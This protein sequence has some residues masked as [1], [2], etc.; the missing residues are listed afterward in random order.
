MRSRGRDRRDCHRALPALR[1]PRAPAASRRAASRRAA[2]AARNARPRPGSQSRRQ[3]SA[4]APPSSSGTQAS[5]S[6]ASSSARQ[7]GAFQ[8]IV[9]GPVD[10]LRIGEVRENPRRRFG[11]DMVAFARHMSLLD[12][13]PGVPTSH[14]GAKRDCV[15][16]RRPHAGV[17]AA[18]SS[19]GLIGQI[20]PGSV[21]GKQR[22]A[23]PAARPTAR[24]HNREDT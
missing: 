24:T 10:G 20:T 8:R 21:T 18:P 23:A 15:G 12:A 14:G 11:D 16:K 9:L 3:D 13:V 17:A 7:S 2:P 6:P 1:C 19:S 5:G 4:P 22:T